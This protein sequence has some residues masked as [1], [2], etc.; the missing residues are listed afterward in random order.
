MN[1]LK[2]IELCALNEWILQ[3]VNYISIKWLFLK[4][5]VKIH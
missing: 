3:Y 4:C 5:E 1:V 2:I